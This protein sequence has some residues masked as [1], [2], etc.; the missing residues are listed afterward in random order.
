MGARARARVCAC[1]CVYTRMRVY[2]CERVCEVKHKYAFPCL[3][4]VHVGVMLSSTLLRL[5]VHWT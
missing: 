1:E 5:A 2:V 3:T 4:C